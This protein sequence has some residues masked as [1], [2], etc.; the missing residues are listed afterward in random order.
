VQE[1]TLEDNGKAK[2]IRPGSVKRI[3]EAKIYTERE[4]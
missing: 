2:K 4:P 1:E 3:G